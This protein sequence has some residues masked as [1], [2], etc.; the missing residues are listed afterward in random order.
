TEQ[1][2]KKKPRSFTDMSS[3]EQQ[4][5]I[6][7][8]DRSYNVSKSKLIEKSD[9]FRALFSSGMREA[10]E[11][12]VQLQ[13]LSAPGLELVLEFINTSK[14]QVD[15][16]TLEDLI[17][18]AS[19]LQVTPI[20]KLLL[21]EIRLDNC[22]EVF[23]LSEVYGTHE[24]RSACLNLMSCHY[25]PMLR[26]PE[27]H[28]LPAE[29]REQIREMRMRGAATLVVLGDLDPFSMLR[30]G[31]REQRWKPFTSNLDPDMNNVRGYG[32]A[33]LDNYLFI[34]GGYRMAS[35]AIAAAHC[36]N[37]C[38]NEWTHVA[39]LNQKRANFKL[40]AVS[41]KLYAIGG[42]GLSTVEC[43][44][45][46]QDWWTCVSSMPNP[47]T[48]FSA[49]E[50]QGMIYVMGGYTARDR[51]MNVLRYC[52]TSDTWS[53]L[54]ACS[55]HIRKQQMLSVEDV[56]YMVGGYTRDLKKAKHAETNHSEDTL[57]V[58]SYN[59]RTREWLQ[60]RSSVSKSGLNLTCALHNDGI[61]IMSR[62]VGPRASLE[63]RVF[64]KYDIFGEAWE[65]L[66]HFPAIGHNVLLC[67]LYLPNIL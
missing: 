51:N 62:D 47:L 33:V 23:N 10:G 65:A 14:V 2:I 64:L 53:V 8:D 16:E 13:G 20:L 61:Y 1:N 40:V 11:A 41:G 29:L 30:Y 17:E 35:Q 66:R 21:S 19:F 44:G 45:P 50:C 37:P 55:A 15:N 63:H 25:H 6:V 46:E 27:F 12:S 39:S 36:Y 43:Y 7:M 4:I 67:S 49:C 28:S 24:L 32:S 56:I 22:V 3:T 48:E 18:T 58:Q 26:R 60:L 54:H 38:R 42:H 59:V 34:A 9:Y 52:P 5:V 31:E 57:T